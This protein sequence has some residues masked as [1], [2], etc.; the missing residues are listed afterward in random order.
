MSDNL[1]L[2]VIKCQQLISVSKNITIGCMTNNNYRDA[3][4][5]RL[6][7]LCDDAGVPP[8]GKNRQAIVGKMFGVSQEAARKWLEGESV[9]SQERIYEICKKWD[10]SYEWVMSGRG[11]K[12]ISYGVAAN[13]PEAHALKI[14]QDM[15]PAEKLRAVKILAAAAQ[16]TKDGTN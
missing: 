10:V 15:T 3:F 8:K 14:M 1:Q 6:N 4:K 13:T 12:R 9:P 11:Q 7:E 5:D 16:P 2:K